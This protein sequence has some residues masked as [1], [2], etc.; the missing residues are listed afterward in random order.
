MI[1]KSVR[2]RI[3]QYLPKES[4]YSFHSITSGSLLGATVIFWQPTDFII[5]SVSFPYRYLLFLFTAIAIV[6]LLWAIVSLSNFDPFGRKQISDYLQNR[7]TETQDFVLRGPYKI[8]RHPFYFFILAMIWLYPVMSV[9][10]L[11]FAL[12]WSCWVVL[13]T[14]LE[15]KDLVEEI[16]EKYV[17]YQSTVPMLIPYKFINNIKG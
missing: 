8:T 13:G 6:G 5:F 1:R 14:K 12:I 10:R 11:L 17:K 3:D 2:N 4:F 9:D 7:K 16:G 15:E